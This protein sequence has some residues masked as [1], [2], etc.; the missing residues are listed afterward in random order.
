M[1]SAARVYRYSRLCGPLRAARYL[2][3]ERR[4]TAAL[5]SVQHPSLA[6]RVWL[7]LGSTDISVAGKV[8]LEREY[9]L[10][11]ARDPAVI[12]DAG[13]YT[14]ISSLWFASRYPNARILALEPDPANYELLR[15]NVSRERRITPLQEALWPEDGMVAIRDAGAGAWG[16]RV[17][18]DAGPKTVKATSMRSL[19]Q[20]M[21]LE[22][23]DLL[24]LDIE[25]AEVE[26]FEADSR[27][28]L[29]VVDAIAVE[30][31]DDIRPG[32]R[33][34]VLDACTDF[35]AFEIGHETLFLQRASTA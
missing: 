34:A 19:M 15:W 14:G 28:W 33:G 8:I 21:G 24:K 31:H 16:H 10:P 35:S 17:S 13:A 27:S 26:L 20:R 25:G 22:R 1:H 30:T 23:V 4:G 29:H 11:L 32:A 6:G 2:A 12:V 3:A 5:L 18:G 7:R 9:V